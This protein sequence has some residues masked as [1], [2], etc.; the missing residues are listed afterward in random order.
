MGVLLAI[1]LMAAS[2]SIVG[3]ALLRL[4]LRTKQSPELLIASGL[5]LIGPISQPLT[6][7]SGVG[8][9]GAEATIALFAA[10]AVCVVVGLACMFFFT[11]RVFH[12]ASVAAHVVA[13]L[14]SLAVGVSYVGAVLAAASFDPVSDSGVATGNWSYGIQVPLL[15]CFGW[16]AW[17][18][19]SHHLRLRRQLAIGLGDPVVSNRFLLF[20]IAMGAAFVMMVLTLGMAL[21]GMNSGT[22]LLPRAVVSAGATINAATMYLAFVP[23]R[24]YLDWVRGPRKEAAG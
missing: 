2:T 8:R 21:F 4:G 22:H 11:V 24:S 17:M 3:V 5:L 1:G 7:L 9:P 12:R 6:H 19:L 18:A 13:A 15:L 16:P 23:P 14:G 20:A 10:S